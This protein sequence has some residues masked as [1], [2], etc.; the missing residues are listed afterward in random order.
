MA[1]TYL[2]EHPGLSAATIGG[3]GDGSWRSKDIFVPHPT[4]PDF[5]K[6]VTRADD[7][8]TLIN[9]EKILPLPIESCVRESILVREAVVV[10]IDRSI[11]GLLVFKSGLADALYDVEY[12][13]AIWPTVQDANSRAEG[14]SQIAKD[15]IYLFSSDV[16]YPRADKN[17]IIRAQVSRMFAAQI[18]EMYARMDAQEGVL[19]LSLSNMEA[20]L[21]QAYVDIVGAELPSLDIDFFQSGIDSLKSI[22]MRRI[23]QKTLDLGGH[24]L[25]SNVVYNYHNM[26]ELARYLKS[27][28]TGENMQ[29]DDDTVIMEHLIADHSSFGEVAVGN[30]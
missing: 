19:K 8:I 10:G 6:Y 26:K 7:R 20:F 9:G 2:K 23:I 30:C 1:Y 15:M 18:D 4:I 11:P 29:V 25:S 24:E 14:F 28:S 22:Q 3:E 5:W 27:L 21:K 16:E 13:D 17:S 12:V